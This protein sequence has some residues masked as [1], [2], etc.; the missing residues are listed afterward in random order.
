MGTD[1]IGARIRDLRK[2]AGMN[3]EDIA[4]ALGVDPSAISN[5]ENGKRS[6]KTSELAKIAKAL[7]VSPLAIL[8]P[9]SLLGRLP[10]AARTATAEMDQDVHLRLTSLAELHT[11]LKEAGIES[12]RPQK[13]WPDLDPE[14]W[15]RTAEQLA[16]WANEQLNF[17]DSEDRFEGLASAMERTLGID[18]LVENTGSDA[19][20]GAAITDPEFPI[21]FVN[22]NQPR[23][24]A[25]F[26]LAHELGH[27]L[28]RDGSSLRVDRNLSGTDSRERLANAF[29]AEL[30]MPRQEID[31]ILD[32]KGRGAA[33][34]AQIMI[35][36]QVSFESMVYRL[37]NLRYINA[38][39]RDMMKSLGF[40]GLLQDLDDPELRTSL[41]ALRA[42]FDQSRPPELLLERL[43][44]GYY[45]GVV[46]VRPLAGL[47]NMDNDELLALLNTDVEVDGDNSAESFDAVSIE[48]LD[49]ATTGTK[50]T[51]EE[52]FTGIPA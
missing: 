8:E 26:T 11:V 2:E 35:Q 14:E 9:D 3:A 10:V 31:A 40:G 49:D 12:K 50:A 13:S 27:V 24:R 43:Y 47:L 21:V 15:L 25:M 46:S 51:A 44:D 41:L 4:E 48:I 19:A 36:L 45:R 32:E 34:L 37:H 29:A 1:L 16:S 30:L 23:A 33:G 5:I 18:V 22:A 7:G 52:L 20:M 38:D 17:S 28:A 42:P 6:V 39:G